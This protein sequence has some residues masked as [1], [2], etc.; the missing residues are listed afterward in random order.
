M[1]GAEPSSIATLTPQ[2]VA[3]AVAVGLLP[4]DPGPC[5]VVLAKRWKGRQALALVAAERY[6]GFEVLRRF[7]AAVESEIP[8]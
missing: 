4:D 5:T 1:L 2:E 6:D 3:R 7:D 8:G